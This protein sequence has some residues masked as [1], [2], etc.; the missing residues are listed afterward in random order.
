MR[1]V[2]LSLMLLLVF[3]AFQ[4]TYASAAQ[5]RIN[6]DSKAYYGFPHSI[7][8]SNFTK[9]ATDND[10]NTKVD[11]PY[12]S[13][14]TFKLD[15]GVSITGLSAKASSKVWLSFYAKDTY[16]ELYGRR[17]ISGDE[18][19]HP[20]DMKNVGYVIV[21]NDT[22]NSTLKLYEFSIFGESNKP[23]APEG[24]KAVLDKNNAVLTWSN[25]SGIGKFNIKR[26]EVSGGAYTTI[27]SNVDA[28]T[29]TDSALELGK[30]YY[31]VVTA[32][33]SNEE[34][35]NS[36]EVSVT[37]PYPAAQPPANL[38][39]VGENNKARLT[40]DGVSGAT[41]YNVKRSLQAGGPY[42]V[43]ANNVTQAT[44]EDL[45]IKAGTTYYYVVTAVNAG[46][47]SGNSNE[48]SVQSKLPALEINIKEE[49]VKVGQEFVANIALKN[50]NNIYA[51]DFS[52][53]YDNHLFE[54]L[55]FEE[56]TG[57]KVYNEPTDQ[58]GTL[59]FIVASQG[60]NYGIKDDKPFLKVKFRAKAVGTGKVDATKCRIADTERE[61]DL[62]AD[63]CLEDQVIVQN[64]DVN[65]SGEYTLLDLAID[66]YYYGELA[67]NVDPVKYE[68]NQAGDEYIRDEDLVFIVKQMLQNTN[69]PPNM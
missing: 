3:S 33:N 6:A 43:I 17:Y 51:E 34:S 5:V 10:P 37:L 9:N 41:G 55:G 4:V 63:S 48:V 44:Y 7:V 18:V 21:Q 29:Y 14:V 54:Y 47:E 69:Y 16:T 1:K 64:M 23:Q 28:T 49:K 15:S 12:P 38:V 46:G 30:T 61:F 20:V 2:L 52:I 50:V 13:V 56:V 39:G 67:T 31:Y 24:L 57:Y 35:A 27:A 53:K 60:K 19:L 26:S 32:V 66:S 22:P 65:K 45:S 58:N 42:T 62:E 11:L 8:E 68:A 40:W 36:N 59:R 25:P